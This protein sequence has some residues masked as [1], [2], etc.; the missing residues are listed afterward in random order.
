MAKSL[1]GVLIKKAHAPQKYTIEEIKHLEAC[2]DPIDGPL[3]FCKNFL[4]IQHPVRGA[5]DFQPYEY[6]ER[7]LHAYHDNKQCIAM[8][9][10]QMGKA[11]SNITPILTSDGFKN[12]GE[13]K[14]GDTIYG[15]DGKST[16]IT[17]ITE[18]MH[19][20]PCYEIEFIH[21]EKIVADAEHLWTWYD[22]HLARET[23]GNTLDLIRRFNMFKDG[24]QSLHIK[25]TSLVEFESQTITIDP[26]YLGVWLGDGGSRDLR[27]TCTDTDYTEYSKIFNDL[28][29]EV[30]HF[31][32]DKRSTRT[33]TFY[34]KGGAQSFK[35]LDLW[36]NKHIPD[37]Y[38]FNDVNV[39]LSLLQ[40]LMDTDGTVEKNGVCRFYQS[41]EKLIKQVRLLLSTL[42]IKSTLSCK[43]TT[44]KDAYT[45]CFTVNDFDVFKL[46]RKLERQRNNKNHPKNKRIYIRSISSTASVPVRCLQVNNESHLFLAGE[47]LV[48]THNTTCATGYLLWYTMF[49]PE[50]QVLIA[51]H[52]YEGAQDIMNRYRYGYEN[53]PDFIR[54][55]VYSYNRNTIEYDNG[56]RIQAT[57]TTENTG[58]GKSL[59]LIYCD[60]FAFVQPPEKAKEFWTAL[61]P[62]LST[63]GKCIITSTPNSDEDQFAL[64][65]TE[66]NKKFDEYGNESKLGQN[67]FFSYFAHWS[68]HPDRDEDWAKEERA[69]IGEE[70]FRR[71]F[72]CEFLIFDETLVNSVNL[73][74]LKGIDPKM[75]MG[76][77]RWYRDINPK[78][79]YLVALDPSLGTGGDY[80]AIQVFEMP[81]M[82]QVA[83][84]HH[85]LT[86]IQAQVKHLREIL[87][88]IHS[89]GEE[90][91][92]APQIYYSVENNTLGEAALIVINDIG[93]ENFHGLFLSEPIRKGHIRKFRKGFNTTHR[94]KISAC[95]QLKNMIET[96]KMQLYSKPL[97]SELKTFVAHGVGFGAKTGEHDDLVTSTLLI[98]RMANV[99]ADWDP[100]IYEKM[101]EK[102]TEEQMPMPIFISTG[103]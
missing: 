67:G 48:P 57:T 27:I 50:A 2:M 88:Y 97:I 31:T 86:P 53:L 103:F 43:P 19:D 94:T 35:K 61:S 51:A 71:E 28:D 84:W 92:G 9:P 42:G 26:Y 21:G 25:H 29:L 73:A 7:L 39:R 82:E 69:K 18:T 93:E 30:S 59:S 54:A 72:D 34:I 22:P 36:G 47:T 11:L 4:K 10:R 56:A 77:T 75:T 14:V 38:I 96:K 58:R 85:N 95:S 66:A 90:R 60:E 65:W 101:S 98:I 64:I 91:G 20:R 15:P 8:L 1:D 87:K 79:T 32:L 37:S 13:L 16:T 23:T 3:Y 74:E 62:T 41:N 68:E 76:Q 33:G 52:K 70:R 63:G 83:E 102:I 55:G 40:G 80:G 81:S 12:M 45:L 5:I 89:R 100:H 6:Q 44:H 17:F 99:L 78:S 24:S 49:V 46:E